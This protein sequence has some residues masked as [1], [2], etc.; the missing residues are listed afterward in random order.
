MKLFGNDL[1]N[2][3]IETTEHCFTYIIVKLDEKMV[4][5]SSIF[6]FYLY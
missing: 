2:A 5:S 3:T 6:R 4:T 1:F